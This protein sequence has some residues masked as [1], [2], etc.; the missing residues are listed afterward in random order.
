MLH[1]HVELP[2]YLRAHDERNC[3]FKA[4]NLTELVIKLLLC[5]INFF[6]PKSVH[7]QHDFNKDAALRSSAPGSD[8]QPRNRHKSPM[9]SPRIFEEMKYLR[10]KV[11]LSKLKEAVIFY[12]KKICFF[13]RLKRS[14][15]V[16]S[17]PPRLPLLSFSSIPFTK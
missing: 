6:L 4:F 13:Q 8:L 15:E 9:R 16:R 14:T 1:P 11:C 7:G 3:P 10:F 12:Y 5:T 17:S 2:F